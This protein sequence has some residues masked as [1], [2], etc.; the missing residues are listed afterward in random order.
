MQPF[1]FPNQHPPPNCFR[2]SFILLVCPYV[3]EKASLR[4]SNHILLIGSA[5]VL[6]NLSSLSFFVKILIRYLVLMS[7]KR[8]IVLAWTSDMPSN[9]NYPALR[10]CDSLS[11][12][13]FNTGYTLVSNFILW[14]SSQIRC[15]LQYRLK[16][17]DDCQHTPKDSCTSLNVYYY[18]RSIVYCKFYPSILH[19]N[20]LM[21]LS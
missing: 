2:I 11:Y 12:K 21:I 18:R 7:L 8:Y 4:I 17:R 10:F 19:P 20:F 3:G 5:L 16:H 9:F 13:S 14:L 6:I 1:I 15:L